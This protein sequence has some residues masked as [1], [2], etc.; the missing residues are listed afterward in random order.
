M[1]TNSE[2]TVWIKYECRKGNRWIAVNSYNRIF[3]DVPGRCVFSG[4]NRRHTFWIV[5][6]TKDREEVDAWFKNANAER[7]ANDPA[8]ARS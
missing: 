7:N 1:N 2:E 3:A 8:E 4:C 6:E 5:G